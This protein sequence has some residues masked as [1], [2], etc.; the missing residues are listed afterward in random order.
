M[1]RWEEGTAGGGRTHASFVDNPQFVLKAPA[2]TNMCIV[3]RDLECTDT[4]RL[5]P[6]F[7]RLCVTAVE[8]AK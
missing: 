5:R 2:G 8:L 3:L 7:L 6:L 1:G 4:K